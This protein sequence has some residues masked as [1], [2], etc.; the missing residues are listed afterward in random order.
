MYLSMASS[1]I[2]SLRNSTKRIDLHLLENENPASFKDCFSP[3]RGKLANY[4]QMVSWKGEGIHPLFPYAM[5]THIHF[6][7]VNKP[8]FPYSPYGLIHKREK[9]TCLKPL[10][11]GAWEMDTTIQEYRQLD[12]GVEIDFLTTLKIDGE[13]CW[14]SLTTAFKRL[15]PSYKKVKREELAIDSDIKWDIPQGYGRKYGLLSLNIDPIHISQMTAKMMGHKAAIM[16]GMW[17]AARG[18]SQFAPT[19]FPQVFEIK[20]VA[21]IYIPNQVQ[22]AQN[23]EG[24][25]IYTQKGDKPHLL[26]D[27]H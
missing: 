23:P 3:P 15:K 20:F 9:I 8:S 13:V 25:G 19:N 2:K 21:P 14:H 6:A 12:N 27:C 7:V 1:F 18:I 24:F 17:A 26:V 10:T 22:Y 4:H 16:H 5:L 11:L